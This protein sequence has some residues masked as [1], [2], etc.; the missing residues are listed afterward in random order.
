[1]LIGQEV[2]CACQWWQKTFGL[3]SELLALGTLIGSFDRVLGHLDADGIFQPSFLDTN[4]GQSSSFCPHIMEAKHGPTSVLRMAKNLAWQQ[5]LPLH[6]IVGFQLLNHLLKLLVNGLV[7]VQ[8]VIHSLDNEQV[9]Q[10]WL[11]KRSCN[12]SVVDL[13]KLLLHLFVFHGSNI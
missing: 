8:D 3:I 12:R 7:G 9:A 2:S 1:M 6:Q 5:N 11:G 10:P 4:I 13:P